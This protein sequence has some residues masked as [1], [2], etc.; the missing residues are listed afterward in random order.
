MGTGHDQEGQQRADD[1]G[2]QPGSDGAQAV[3]GR[4]Q[5]VGDDVADGAQ[6]TQ[7]GNAH[8]QHGDQRCGEEADGLGCHTVG[9]GLHLGHQQDAQQDGDNRRRIGG[10]IDGQAKDGDGLAGLL[11][12]GDH[13]D[14]VGVD[15]DTAQHHGQVG[16][17]AQLLGGR[18]GQQDGQ[19][20]EGGVGHEVDDLVGAGSTVH[21]FECHQDGQNGLQHAGCG[22]RRQDG[23]EDAGDSINQTAD[24]RA[25]FLFGGCG[26][27][28]QAGQQSGHLFVDLGDLCA[29]DDLVLAVGRSNAHHTRGA[30]D[31]LGVRL[32]LIL[33]IEAQTG[34]A[35]GHV[36]DVALAAHQLDDCFGKFFV[37]CLLCHVQFLLT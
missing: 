17:A 8:H 32:A 9:Q 26:C 25:L 11:G 29:D 5:D 14:K 13:A 31:C 34:D 12:C 22:Q 3:D 2:S 19:E 18:V 15:Q 30:A 21:Q 35:V 7:G 20:V 1:G 23:G 27:T 4:S 36:G 6:H 37:V 16:V 28:A 33:Q 24:H 10:V